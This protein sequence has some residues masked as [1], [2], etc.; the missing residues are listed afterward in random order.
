MKE[1]GRIYARGASAPARV[2]ER[3]Q[4][5]YSHWPFSF[6]RVTWRG[7]KTWY[8]VLCIHF[9]DILMVNG[10]LFYLKARVWLH[11]TRRNQ[12]QL[13]DYYRLYTAKNNQL[14]PISGAER[15]GA[16][17]IQKAV[18]AI[19]YMSRI[20]SMPMISTT[21]TIRQNCKVRTGVSL[22]KTGDAALLAP[23]RPT[24]Q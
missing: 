22:P 14:H 18:A 6:G 20:L 8:W 19:S 10:I 4:A 12:Q 1:K 5:C 2:H 15:R 24:Q 21:T 11:W 7:L 17:I 23:A 9:P 13:I 16:H 3:H